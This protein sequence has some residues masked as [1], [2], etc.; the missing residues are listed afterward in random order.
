MHN[1]CF[2]QK[3]RDLLAT[4][5]AMPC[6]VPWLSHILSKKH[7]NTHTHL[8]INIY[9]YIRYLKHLALRR[10][11]ICRDSPPTCNLHNVPQIYIGRC[12]RRHHQ[13]TIESAINPNRIN[14]ERYVRDWLVCTLQVDFTIKDVIVVGK[15][16][17]WIMK[18]ILNSVVCKIVN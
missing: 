12:R 15:K 7:P 13:P 14:F 10:L 9:S 8:Y 18:Y 6:V 5:H 4:H 11:L 2:A 16:S 17:L 1:I 3:L